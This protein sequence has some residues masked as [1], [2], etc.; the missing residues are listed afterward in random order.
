MAQPDEGQKL[1]APSAARNAPDLSAFLCQ[2]APQSGQA[3]EIASGTGQHVV[4]FAAALPGLTWQPTDVA[5]DRLRSIDAYARD[6][7]L[8]N[9]RP[10]AHLD[11]LT[12][13][14]AG[15]HGPFDLILLVN[16]LHLITDQQAQT[17]IAEI[18]QCLRPEG[19]FVLYG[20]FKRAGQLTSA[21]DKQFDADLR[22]A[23]PLIGYK[24][25]LDI[26]RWLADAGLGADRVEMPANNI[27]FVCRKRA[28]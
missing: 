23:D 4:T 27:A 14:W 26:Q 16:L 6:A 15:S 3:L 21:G 8:S 7:G 18:S 5:P 20:P 17:A 2:H 28:P 24:D 9:L 1:H 12:P 19:V 10:A 13:G 11:A 22:G 25:T